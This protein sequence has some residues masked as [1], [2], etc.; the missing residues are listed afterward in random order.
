MKGFYNPTDKELENAWNSESTLFV[1]DTNTFLNLYGYADQTREDFFSILEKIKSRVWIPYH[2]ALEYQ[3]NRIRVIKEEKNIFSKIYANLKKIDDVF[4]GNFK[5][6]SLSERIPSLAESTSVLHSEIGKVIE[7]YRK[8]VERLDKKQPCVNSAD[9]I[10]NKLDRIFSDKV[11]SEPESQRWL[12]ELYSD[13]KERYLKKHP[14]GY[15]DSSKKDGDEPE[16]IYSDL[17]YQRQYG[18]LIIWKQIIAKA[19]DQRIKSILFVTDD[20]KEDWWQTEE[21]RGKKIIGPRPELIEEI[22]RKSSVDLFMMYKTSDFLEVGG[23]VLNVEVKEE[24]LADAKNVFESIRNITEKYNEREKYVKDLLGLTDEKSDFIDYY[25]LINYE[26]LA[27]KDFHDVLTKN[28]VTEEEA[29]KIYRSIMGEDGSAM[30]IA[31][32]SRENNIAKKMKFERFLKNE[33]IAENK[34]IENSYKN[35]NDE[36]K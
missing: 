17:T 30:H 2:V 25:N 8:N 9:A 22:C 13:G 23:K 10:R 32:K 21:S 3:R 1:F 35:L 16:Y 4:T 7:T 27:K 19:S 34:G 11:G 24:S 14:P 29:R 18:D 33:I 5:D 20:A 6:L 15:K 28:P 26:F 31:A 36:E 12:D